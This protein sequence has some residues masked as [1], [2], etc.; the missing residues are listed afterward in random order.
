MKYFISKQRY[1][2]SIHDIDHLKGE[3]RKTAA[4]A[5]PEQ[6]RLFSIESLDDD[7]SKDKDVDRSQSFH[8][9][10]LNFD[11]GIELSDVTSNYRDML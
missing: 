2:E 6:E 10:L 4:A 8:D 9:E 3:R 7:L 5:F 1:L 11:D